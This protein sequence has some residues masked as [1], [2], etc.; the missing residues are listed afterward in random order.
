MIFAKR[1]NL[2]QIA[3]T[4]PSE[5]LMYGNRLKPK[6][7][8]EDRPVSTLPSE[9]SDLCTAHDQA[10]S[11]GGHSGEV[12]ILSPLKVCCAQKILLHTYNEN[13][14]LAPKNAFANQ[15]LRRH[16]GPTPVVYRIRILESNPPGYWEF[17]DLDWIPFPL[18]PDAVSSEISDL[19]EISDLLLLCSLFCFSEYRNKVLHLLF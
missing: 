5:T 16:N 6:K 11:H 9:I 18:Q 15:T 2:W 3:T 12:Y 13:K 17:L 10:Q 4:P 19:C 1:Q 14:N 7:H 8:E